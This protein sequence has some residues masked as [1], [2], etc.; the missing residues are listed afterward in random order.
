VV[1]LIGGFDLSPLV[2]LLL[3]QIV[4]MVINQAII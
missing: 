1:P 3:V 2:L 4:L